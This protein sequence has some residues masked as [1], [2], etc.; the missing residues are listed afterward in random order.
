MLFKKKEFKKFKKQL[1]QE[2]KMEKERLKNLKKQAKNVKALEDAYKDALCDHKKA[3]LKNK[4]LRKLKKKTILMPLLRILVNGKAY[5]DF[6]VN[7]A[8]AHNGPKKNDI[9]IQMISGG[10]RA[11]KRTNTLNE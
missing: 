8:T 9:V 6:V 10:S 2:F 4:Y 1:S 7:F 11:A 3:K 5:Q